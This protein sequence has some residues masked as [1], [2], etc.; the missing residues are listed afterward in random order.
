[1]RNLYPVEC[2]IWHRSSGRTLL[3]YGA[4]FLSFVQVQSTV[5]LSDNNEP[6]VWE[7]FVS[8]HTWSMQHTFCV[9]LIVWFQISLIVGNYYSIWHTSENGPMLCCK[10]T[11]ESTCCTVFNLNISFDVCSSEFQALPYLLTCCWFLEGP[12]T[13]NFDRCLEL[14]RD[15]A[16]AF[17]EGHP[18][19]PGGAGRQVFSL[20]PSCSFPNLL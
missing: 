11:K 6:T 13:S 5:N 15:V 1:M 9:S 14:A 3:E 18:T 16:G 4:L 12:S 20:G 8:V 2:P 19:P 10:Q 17:R 7:G